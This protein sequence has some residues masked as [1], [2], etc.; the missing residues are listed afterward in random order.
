MLLAL[1]TIR[2]IG[3]TLKSLGFSSS[4]LYKISSIFLNLRSSL[5]VLFRH[6]FH[7]KKNNKTYQATT[8]QIKFELKNID[9]NHAYTLRVAI[10]SATFAELQVRVYYQSMT[11]FVH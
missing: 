1:A 10:A 9:K 11:F 2:K 3:F 5:T 6:F 4:F 8:W 7:R